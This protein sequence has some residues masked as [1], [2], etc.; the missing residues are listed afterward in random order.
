MMG[1]MLTKQ[2]SIITNLVKHADNMFGF[3]RPNYALGLGLY[4]TNE[5]IVDL[6]GEPEKTGRR[7]RC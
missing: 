1:T 2:N 5:L 3:A 4:G 6:A 7:L